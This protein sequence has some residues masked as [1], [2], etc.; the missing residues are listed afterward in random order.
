[1]RKWKYLSR[2][3]IQSLKTKT[4]NKAIFNLL[5]AIQHT[6]HNIDIIKRYFKINILYAKCEKE[7]MTSVLNMIREVKD[8][9]KSMLN[10]AS[11]SPLPYSWKRNHNII[12]ICE[13]I[14]GEIGQYFQ[15]LGEIRRNDENIKRS[16][17]N[18]EKHLSIKFGYKFACKRRIPRH[19]LLEFTSK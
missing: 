17:G 12:F 6:R 15:K 19:F 3:L 18:P 8:C 16:R 5:K 2:I 9:E 1:M 10:L 11:Y 13:K 4:V 7:I 14:W